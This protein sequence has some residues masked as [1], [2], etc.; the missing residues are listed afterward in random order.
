MMENRPPLTSPDGSSNRNPPERCPRPLYSRDSTQEDQEEKRINLTTVKVEVKEE[1]L[2]VSS[3]EACKEEDPPEISTDPGD[4]QRDVKAE[5][6][7]EGHVRIKQEEVPIKIGTDQKDLRVIERTF[8][9]EEGKILLKIKDEET[10]PKS[11]N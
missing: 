6:E 11:S 4:T 8:K 2:Y 9:A 10:P 7:E 1:D 3:D 5:E